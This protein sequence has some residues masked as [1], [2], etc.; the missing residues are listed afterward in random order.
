[1]CIL[2]N[3]LSAIKL[4]RTAANVD[5]IHANEL[6]I[7]FWIPILAIDCIFIYAGDRT[8]YDIIRH[9]YIRFHDQFTGVVK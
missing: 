4:H 5:F 2:Y 6:T 9:L 1:M 3:F 8:I 7:N